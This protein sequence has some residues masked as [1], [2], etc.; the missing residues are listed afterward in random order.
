MRKFG[1]EDSSYSGCVGRVYLGN[2]AASSGI[3]FFSFGDVPCIY[4][5]RNILFL[6][7]PIYLFFFFI[8][9]VVLKNFFKHF[10]TR[11]FTE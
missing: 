8:Y 11:F 9:Q 1:G 3:V 2:G 5:E 6:Q 4:F 7:M 10:H